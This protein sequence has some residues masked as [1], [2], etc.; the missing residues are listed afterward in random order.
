MFAAI[1][2]YRRSCP[3]CKKV[4]Q[5]S[6]FRN[7]AR[8]GSGIRVCSK[9]KQR[10]EDSSVE[11]SA[12][13]AAQRRSFLWGGSFWVLVVSGRAISSILLYIVLSGSWRGEGPNPIWEILKDLWLAYGS[14]I[15]LDLLV[16]WI[17]IF[18]SN[19]RVSREF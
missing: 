14:I 12:M 15:A 9:C 7:R 1:T 8:I 11:W 10:F 4:F 3:Y 13:T 2:Y 19:R 17:Q 16:C 6:L 18:R 5:T